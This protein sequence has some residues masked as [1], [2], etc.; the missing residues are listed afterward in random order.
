MKNQRL[1]V[2][3]ERIVQAIFIM[4]GQKV[5]LDKNLADL[6][7]VTTSVLNKA[8]SR[9]VDRFPSD[10]MFQLTRKEFAN[11]KFQFGTSSWGGTRKLPRAFTEQGVAMLSSVLRSTRAVQVNIQ[12]MRAFV[13]LRQVLAS[14]ADLARKLEEL[15]KKYDAQF[16]VVFD[17]LRALMAETAPPKRKIGFTAKDQQAVYTVKRKRG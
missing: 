4:R 17:A 12:I 1:L 6:Y 14:H 16:R 3:T 5:I 2:P 10:F 15:E 7:G 13:R 8:V 11:L 9:N